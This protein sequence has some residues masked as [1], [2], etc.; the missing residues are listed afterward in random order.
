MTPLE[1]TEI[2]QTVFFG[3][4]MGK[5]LRAYRPTGDGTEVDVIFLDQVEPMLH[6]QFTNTCI[7]KRLVGQPLPGSKADPVKTF[8]TCLEA[9]VLD[10]FIAT[11]EP[12]PQLD[13]MAS[14]VLEAN[15]SAHGHP[16]QGWLYHLSGDSAL[17]VYEYS[18]SQLKEVR[19]GKF[20]AV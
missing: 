8:Q 19:R 10:A 5:V 20:E 14:S 7:K 11:N 1:L 18:A 4:F 2:A 3:K 6:I 17:S 12:L 15:E 13:A 9:D 16:T